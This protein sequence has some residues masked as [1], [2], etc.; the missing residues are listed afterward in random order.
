[1]EKI[2]FA[3]LLK[4]QKEFFRSGKTRD[5]NFRIE[6]LTKL[7]NIIKTHEEEVL[8]AIYED[9]HKASIDGYVTEIS[10]VYGEIKYALEN[11]RSWAKP[12]KVET[13]VFL[14]PSKSYV[15]KDP[16]GVTCNL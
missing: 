2:S 3:G 9:L 4:S 1:M 14:F 6:T 7:K 8:N 11:V 15:Q 12:E 16:Y 10:G 5:L 13:P